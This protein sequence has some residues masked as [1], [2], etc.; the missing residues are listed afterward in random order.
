MVLVKLYVYFLLVGLDFLHGV[1]KVVHTG[2]HFPSQTLSFI[3]KLTRSDLK[4]DN[5]V[6]TFED[7]SVL[8]DFLNSYLEDEED[9]DHQPRT[10]LHKI[11]FTGR[12]IYLC[13]NDFGPLQKLKVS[14]P[15]SWT[16]GQ[17]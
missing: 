13:H 10:M 14:C 12:P 7:P 9:Q 11:D 2:P 15:S 6:V 4:P 3:W 8:A 1:C 17:L 5:I 16:W